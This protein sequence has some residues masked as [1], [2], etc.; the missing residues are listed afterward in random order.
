[1]MNPLVDLPMPVEDIINGIDAVIVTHLHLDHWDDIAKEV[2]PKEIKLFVQDENDAN[3][4]RLYGFKNVEVLREDT[5]FESIQL[6]K[7]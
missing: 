1:Q 6:V 3:E 7:T 5:V 4:I 2:L